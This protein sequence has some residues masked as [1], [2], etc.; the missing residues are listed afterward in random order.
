[1]L[2]T[3]GQGQ[4]LPLDKC[5]RSLT[6][7]RRVS[8]ST[9]AR[10]LAAQSGASTRTCKDAIGVLNRAGYADTF[11]VAGDARAKLYAI[12]ERGQRVLAH[13]AGPTIL[14][15]ARKLFST[16]ASKRTL[17]QRSGY[18][19]GLEPAD[20]LQRVETLILTGGY[21]ELIRQNLR[22][23]DDAQR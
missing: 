17:Q 8:Y 16:C 15:Y 10:E 20:A 22:A 12:S 1:L 9:Y 18:C 23:P 4:Q 6:D 11:P 7:G 21:A 2:V 19:R 5:L 13:R 14:R 3:S